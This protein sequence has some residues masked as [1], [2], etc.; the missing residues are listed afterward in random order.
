M[1]LWLGIQ[2]AGEWVSE[3]PGPVFCLFLGV[4]SDY[5]Q[6]ITGQVTDATCA[7]I[8]RAQPE[9][10]LSKR[11]KSGP[12]FESILV[13]TEE[14]SSPFD[15]RSLPWALAQSNWNNKYG[16]SSFYGQGKMWFKDLWTDV[17]WCWSEG[18]CYLCGNPNLWVRYV[19][20]ILC[21]I[22]CGLVMP[23]DNI[24]LSQFRLR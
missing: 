2:P 14:D 13:S 17:L 1:D 8:G 10:T 5:A 19:K 23:H 22:H 15:S 16:Y 18:L 7:V 3:A 6:P 21:L 11:Q 24:D 12:G 20:K 4:S 9:L